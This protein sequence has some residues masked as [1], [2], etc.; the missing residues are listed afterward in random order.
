MCGLHHTLCNHLQALYCQGM[1]TPRVKKKPATKK[2]P[3]KKPL[4]AAL[5]KRAKALHDAGKA[6]DVLTVSDALTARGESEQTGGLAYLGDIANGGF[7]AA[8]ARSY[9]ATIRER[10]TLRGLQQIGADVLAAC[11]SPA[12]RAPAEIAAEAEAG[13][14]ALLDHSDSDPVRL[15]DVLCD[16]LADVDERRERGGNLAGLATGFRQL[17]QMTGGL[18]PGQLVIVAARPSVGKTVAGCNIA[19][20]VAAAGG[21]VLFFTLDMSRREIAAKFDEVVAFAEVE[22][23]LDTPVKRYS[24]GMYVRL[25]FAVAAHLEPEIL[26]IDEVLA[27]GDATFQ[28]KCLGKMGEVSKTGRTILFVS[29]NMQAITRL[30]PRA[31]LLDRGKVIE[32]NAAGKAKRMIGLHTDISE[33]KVLREQALEREESL[34]TLFS[35]SPLGIAVVD[36]DTS[37][38]LTVNPKFCEILGRHP[39]E[40]LRLGW[41][42]FT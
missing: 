19:A 20:H 6:V 12:G 8:N 15:H 14:L 3:T 24:S 32:R 11:A 4:P 28:R 9:A 40:L 38:I 39:D 29:H 31:I 37:A 35:E 7:M 17:D 42:D 22:K 18:E 36:T 27:V 13:M 33:Q 1:A 5:A 26:I 30:C 23:F 2:L 25:A 21:P 34:A 10:A 16:V 41:E